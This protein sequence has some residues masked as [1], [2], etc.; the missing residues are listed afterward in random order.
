MDKEYLLE[1]IDNGLSTYKISE[2]TN[3]SQTTVRYWLKK[4]NIK[5]NN[6]SFT[7]GYN[8]EKI[9]AARCK[10]KK[11]TSCGVVLTLENTYK[12]KSRKILVS[13][14]KKCSAKAAKE[15]W[16][17]SKK[18]AV[19]YMGGKCVKC[20]YDKCIDALEFHH[21]NPKEKD[22]NF[23]NLKLKKWEIQ[24]KELDK[25]ICVCANCHREIH[26]ELRL[27]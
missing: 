22:K 3:K 16:Q 26:Y 14:C 20:G 27:N 23:S 19:E 6:Q 11:C 24:K 5:T 10:N 17:S 1:L 9:D 15:R 21:I 7:N 8:K 18:R 12:S 13:T 4:F 25:C 2:I